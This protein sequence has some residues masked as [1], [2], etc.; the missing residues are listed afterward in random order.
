VPDVC[1]ARY[2]AEGISFVNST[3]PLVAQYLKDE[4]LRA[5]YHHADGPALTLKDCVAAV[6]YHG[7]RTCL[8][9][10][11][12]SCTNVRGLCGSCY[13]PRVLHLP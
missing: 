3:L 8:A 1:A 10:T 5:E 6:T 11:L 12:V 13:L 4:D 2:A 7:Y 9:P